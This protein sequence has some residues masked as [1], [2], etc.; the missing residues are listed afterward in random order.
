MVKITDNLIKGFDMID[1]MDILPELRLAFSYFSPSETDRIAKTAAE[2]YGSN[3]EK[4]LKDLPINK[5]IYSA[6]SELEKEILK[7]TRWKNG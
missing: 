3:S 5:E 7:E 6:G 4:L 1:F 2:L